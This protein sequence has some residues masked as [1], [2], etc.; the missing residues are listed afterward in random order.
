[1]NT[2]HRLFNTYPI[3]NNNVVDRSSLVMSAC[4]SMCCLSLC[5]S[6]F[7][8]LSL[9]RCLF[10]LAIF[11]STHLSEKQ[12]QQQ[13]RTSIVQASAFSFLSSCH[14]CDITLYGST[15][16]LSASCFFAEPGLSSLFLSLSRARSLAGSMRVLL[17]VIILLRCLSRSCSSSVTVKRQ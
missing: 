7:L 15:D 11:S 12:Q 6:F 9:F 17:V 14:R 5:F 1:M 10:L 2:I 4:V 8:S 3:T 13:Q 16:V